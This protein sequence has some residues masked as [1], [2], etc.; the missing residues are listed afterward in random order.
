MNRVAAERPSGRVPSLDGLRGIAALIVVFH[1]LALLFTPI[2]AATFAARS[3]EAY[4]EPWSLVWWMT[5]SPA[6]LLLAGP[7]SVLIFFVLSGLVVT[8][9]VL[10]RADFSWIS[11]YPQR[12]ARLY[13]PAAASVLLAL[14]LRAVADC[15]AAEGVGTAV[16]E[17]T[18][19]RSVLNAFDL[20]SGSFSLNE[21]LWTL[22]WEVIFSILLPLFVIVAV[23]ART[24]WVLV[25]VAAG[26]ATMMGSFFTELTSFSYL[27]VFL[28]GALLAVKFTSIQR[29]AADPS[30][31]RLVWWLGLLGFV[32]SVLTITLH[33]SVVG[34]FP[35]KFRLQALAMSVQFVGC[36]GIVL[37]AAFW[38]PAARALST[39]FC[40][41]LGRVSFSLYLVHTPVIVA[42][43]TIIGPG[44]EI[45]T[46]GVALVVSAIL[47]EMFS[48]LIEVPSHK[49]SKLIGT[50][51]AAAMNRWHARSGETAGA[52]DANGH[53]GSGPLTSKVPV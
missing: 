33:A 15:F 6:Y 36:V 35:G 51:S 41:W 48:R 7:E 12:L 34:A 42:A 50:R 40:Q 11:Y 16:G 39:K 31:A 25:A 2:Y 23:A 18:S 46:I 37:V 27:P 14:V 47:A 8:L 44:R 32:L 49:L 17:G 5:S 9:P 45:V 53:D 13:I 4:S 24:R 1:H 30:R 21:P 28:L 3:P 43:Y 10:N 52:S 22:R 19:W 20:V 38:V 29:W 26:I